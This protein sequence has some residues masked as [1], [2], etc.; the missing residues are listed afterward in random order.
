MENAKN[1]AIQSENSF[2]SSMCKSHMFATRKENVFNERTE[3]WNYWKIF[4]FFLHL[5]FL[6]NTTCT[7]FLMI[8][9]FLP[10][11]L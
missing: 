8:Y 2:F 9:K 5:D 6:D 10:Y 3:F 11:E 1:K 4:N 7:Y